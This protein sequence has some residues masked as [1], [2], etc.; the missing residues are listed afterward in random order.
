[1]KDVAETLRIDAGKVYY[2]CLK[3]HLVQFEHP[4]P[5]K[6][7]EETG[8]VGF[9]SGKTSEGWACPSTDFA[10]NAACLVGV[11]PLNFAAMLVC[12]I[13]SLSSSVWAAVVRSVL[14]RIPRRWST[15]C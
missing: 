4:T 14:L 11:H 13:P 8:V 3:F 10:V 9:E 5:N 7:K 6:P 1:M 2:Q 12:A 15:T